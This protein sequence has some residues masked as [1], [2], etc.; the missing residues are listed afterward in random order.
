VK[1]RAQEA[2]ARR[3]KSKRTHTMQIELT[4]AFR[5]ACPD[6][7]FGAL[8]AR[9]CPNRP[10]AAAFGPDR[11][12][13]E[14]RLRERLAGNAIDADPTAA[15]YAG[16]FRRFG[17]RYPVVHQA[18]AIAAGRAIESSSALVEVMF[19]AELDSLV[20]TS[21]HDLHALDGPL[22]VDVAGAGETYTKISGKEQA[23]RPGDMVVRDAEGVI[24]CVVFGPDLRTRLREDS[25]AAL[26]GAWC[27]VGIPARTVEAHLTTLAALLRR[28]W[29][30][31]EVEAPRV[32]RAAG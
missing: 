23:I 31:A 25:D 32:L 17:G 30:G 5:A 16:Y 20:L 18:K 27:P 12:T 19:T 21:G 9:G 24:A 29:P 28:E 11:P 14:T 3:E 22:R 2:T 4:P 8:I 1:P 15:A 10:M 7:V 13:V 26:F 6:G